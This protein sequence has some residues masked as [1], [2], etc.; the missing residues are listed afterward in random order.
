[1]VEDE[2]ERQLDAGPGYSKWKDAAAEM[3][4]VDH[5]KIAGMTNVIQPDELSTI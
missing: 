2:A 5:E 1:M 3:S 4:V